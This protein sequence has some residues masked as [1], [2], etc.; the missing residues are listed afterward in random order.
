MESERQMNRGGIVPGYQDE[1]G[2]SYRPSNGTEGDFF[3]DRFCFHC[4]RDRKFQEGGDGSEG[5]DILARTF[6]LDE[7]DPNYPTE[8]V[9]ADE[10]GDVVPVCTAFL[11]IGAQLPTDADLEALGQINALLVDA[12]QAPGHL[13]SQAE[14]LT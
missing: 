5:C 1:V 13:F 2:A 3:F 7:D 6:A 8:W 9:W 12:T 4:E 10:D 14:S 11:P